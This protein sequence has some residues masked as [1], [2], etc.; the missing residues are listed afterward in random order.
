MQE[1]TAVVVGVSR[2]GRL[3][4]DIGHRHTR[5]K[6][7]YARCP[8]IRL[9]KV[10]KLL[11]LKQKLIEAD[12]VTLIGAANYILLVRKGSKEDPS[13]PEQTANLKENLHYVAKLPV[14]IS[15]HRLVI[16]IITP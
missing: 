13:Y 16:D 1:R 4:S 3:N 15:D 10:F 8:D 11:D 6:P 2:R 5:T 7:D 12:R 14:I 9:K